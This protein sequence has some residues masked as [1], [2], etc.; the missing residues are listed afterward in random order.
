MT[1][2]QK[3]L[4]A[5]IMAISFLHM[6]QMALTPGI[7][8]MTK[9]FTS[10]SVVT[11]QLGVTL[12]PLVTVF[13]SILAAVLIRFGVLTR[14]SAVLWGLAIFSCSG[15]FI[16]LL[17]TEFWH[18]IAS[19]IL[20]GAGLGS[21]QSNITSIMI[22]GFDDHGRKLASGM[23][24]SF[25][26]LGGIAMS[27]AAGFLVTK[28]WYAGY[29]LFLIAAPIFILCLFTLPKP[30]RHPQPVILRE[31]AGSTAAISGENSP[32]PPKTGRL[33]DMPADVYYISF[34]ASFMFIIIYAA[35][36]NNLSLHYAASGV[37]DYAQWTGTSI[38]L[39]MAVSAVCGIF[40]RRISSKLGDYLIA[41]GFGVLAVGFIIIS[42]FHASLPMMVIGTSICGVA[43]ICCSPQGVMALSRYCDESNSFY[44]TMFFSAVTN[45]LGGFL[46]TP[47]ITGITEL[48]APGNTIFR[49][50]FM[51]ALAIAT[52]T[53]FAITTTVRKKKGKSW[54]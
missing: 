53:T 16:L 3:I 30:N 9:V 2:K 5:T 17:H 25:V 22:D 24:G 27:F 13:S 47:V 44:A 1:K 7:E 46:T 40:F 45:G 12:P 29:I 19:G 31:V 38:A 20:M 37:K 18:I 6:P 21:F 14:R 36:A 39:N 26:S 32:T 41:C 42:T 15:V 51:S 8:G 33:R 4:F 35:L 49:Y 28:L 10:M 43:V 23:Q 50:A 34:F 48:I 11:I 52:A 54:R